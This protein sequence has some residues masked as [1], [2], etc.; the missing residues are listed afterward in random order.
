MSKELI[1]RAKVI[2]LI[3]YLGYV[4]VMNKN[5]FESNCRMDRIRQAINELP[6]A[7]EKIA[8]VQI[9]RAVINNGQEENIISEK[10]VISY[11]FLILSDAQ[12]FSL[13]KAVKEAVKD[14][15]KT[16]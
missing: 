4:N 10:N 2:S 3:D 6:E 1:S 14:Y 11:P 15:L 12:D 16:K 13:E 8:E 7:S 5:D 9:V